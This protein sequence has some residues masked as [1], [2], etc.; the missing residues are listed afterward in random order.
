MRANIKINGMKRV[1]IVGCGLGGLKLATSLRN[2]GYQVV[3]VDNSA[4]ASEFSPF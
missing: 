4:F 2:S 1:V 3:I